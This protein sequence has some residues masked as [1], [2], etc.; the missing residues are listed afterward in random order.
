MW[1]IWYFLALVC[2]TVV[3]AV[4]WHTETHRAKLRRIL[5]QYMP[6]LEEDDGSVMV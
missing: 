4:H 1:N 5:H 2:A 3:G 6:L